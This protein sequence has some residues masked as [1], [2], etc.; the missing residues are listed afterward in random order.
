MILGDMS[1]IVMFYR[2]AVFGDVS[3]VPWWSK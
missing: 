3:V 1:G 2:Y